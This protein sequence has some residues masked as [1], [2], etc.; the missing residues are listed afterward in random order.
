[1]T[2]KKG[3]HHFQGKGARLILRDMRKKDPTPHLRNTTASG[4]EIVH[5]PFLQMLHDLLGSVKF[6][7]VKN[8][9]INPSLADHFSQFVSTN[10]R[11]ALN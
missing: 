9:C 8:L 6:T 11:I 4:H 5:F 2:C 7:D 1:M 3:I 10:L